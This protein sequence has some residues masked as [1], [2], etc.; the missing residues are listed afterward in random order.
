[1][2]WWGGDY[3]LEPISAGEE[4]LDRR[5]WDMQMTWRGCDYDLGNN[6]KH[7]NKQVSLLRVSYQLLKGT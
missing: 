2:T 7:Y 3:A 4:Q 5:I 1:M 6:A